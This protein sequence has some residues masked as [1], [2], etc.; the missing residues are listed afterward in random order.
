M[1]KNGR[2]I[3]ERKNAN[4]LRIIHWLSYGVKSGAKLCVNRTKKKERMLFYL[5]T[6]YLIRK[7]TE[8]YSSAMVSE[9][10]WYVGQWNLR[11]IHYH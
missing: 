3:K 1:P 11:L 10:I 9:N 7:Q 6:K 8:P 4:T 5:H 2:K